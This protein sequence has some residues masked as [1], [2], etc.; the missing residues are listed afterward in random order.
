MGAEALGQAG[1]HAIRQYT[2]ELNP[3]RSPG[4]ARL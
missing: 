4:E 3:P 1:E 2:D